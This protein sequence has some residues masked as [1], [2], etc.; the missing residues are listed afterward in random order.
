MD[1][2]H[3]LVRPRSLSPVRHEPPGTHQ[4]LSCLIFRLTTGSAAGRTSVGGCNAVPQVQKQH[5]PPSSLDFIFFTVRSNIT[6]KLANNSPLTKRL[7]GN[8]AFTSEVPK[9]NSAAT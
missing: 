7:T 6:C 3:L 4:S 5:S 1:L 2:S 8:C 9:R